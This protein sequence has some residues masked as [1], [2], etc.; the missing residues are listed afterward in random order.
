MADSSGFVDH[1]IPVKV[2]SPFSTAVGYD[3]E[4]NTHFYQARGQSPTPFFVFDICLDTSATVQVNSDIPGCCFPWGMCVA[5]NGKVYIGTADMGHLFEYDPLSK[6]LTDLGRPGQQAYIWTLA[7]GTDNKIYG[8]TYG[9]CKLIRYDP[10]TGQ[11]DDLGRMDPTEQYLRTVAAD[12]DGYIYGGV[13]SARAGLIAY[14]IES[15]TWEQLIP[16]DKRGPGWGT[17]HMGTD[18]YCYATSPVGSFR[19]Q[20]GKAIPVETPAKKMGLV[21]PDGRM[22][23]S[24]DADRKYLIVKSATDSR[25]IRY[26]YETEDAGT[27]IFVVDKGPDGKVYGSSFLPLQLFVYDP[28]TDQSQNLGKAT[29]STGEIYSF[30]LFKNQLVM[31]AYPG[32][33]MAVYD[34]TL[35]YEIGTNP[36]RTP[37]LSKL[38]YRPHEMCVSPDGERVLIGGIPDYGMLGGAISV[39][40]PE[41]MEIEAEYRN[42][43]PNQSVTT[44]CLDAKGRVIAGSCTQG[45]SGSHPTETEA[46]LFI[47][48][49]DKRE[50]AFDVVPITGEG[51]I[52]AV[53]LG[54]DGLLYGLTHNGHFFVFNSDT[55]EILHL[56]KLPYGRP[57]FHPMELADNGRFYVTFGSSIVEITPG[58]YEHRV[59]AEYSG[60][61]HS[62]IALVGGRIYFSSQ[63]HLLSY[64]MP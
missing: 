7:E 63:D 2:S 19:L 61:I 10:A 6:A 31:A 3:A 15:A 20:G 5:S 28:E 53:R 50:L 4:G 9:S 26:D 33:S 54:P 42:I 30:T 48:D 60:T 35:P 55:R 12:L 14:N 38:V 43:I 24:H 37:G 52:R 23:T 17:V 34:P 1:G 41:T 49:Y 44:I 51:I 25:E 46:R 39:F 21:L 59:L 57:T 29:V 13:G 8:G 16:E 56:E 47:W 40:N 45:G 22:I 36:R 11:S 27:R 18:G 32:A 58:T 62:G 64:P